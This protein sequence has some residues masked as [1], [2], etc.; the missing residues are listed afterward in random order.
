M[1]LVLAMFND[2]GTAR[3]LVTVLRAGG[4]NASLSSLD[5][6]KKTRRKYKKR[7]K[8]AKKV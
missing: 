2:E 8:N 1:Y 6:E 7:R 4:I 5:G 3:T